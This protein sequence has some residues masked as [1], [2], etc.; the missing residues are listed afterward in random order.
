MNTNTLTLFM[1]KHATKFII[2]A[3][4]LA[5]TSATAQTPAAERSGLSAKSQLGSAVAASEP[6]SPE[7][8]Y[9]EHC[10][11]IREEDL[12]FEQQWEKASASE[13]VTMRT[14]RLTQHQT[15]LTRM[16]ELGK[17]VDKRRKESLNHPIPAALPI[18]AAPQA[19]HAINGKT[20]K[21]L[22]KL[23]V[24]VKALHEKET[25]QP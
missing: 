11:K 10:R 3:G 14:T 17:Q 6:L 22:E 19:E 15:R 4:A 5:L 20:G 23:G 24:A 8:E 25:P 18:A 12:A 9:R 7:D 1:I 2:C 13:R 16:N 21:E